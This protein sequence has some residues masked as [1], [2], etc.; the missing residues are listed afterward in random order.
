MTEKPGQDLVLDDQAQELYQQLGGID[1]R[2]RGRDTSGAGETFSDPLAEEQELMDLWRMALVD[3]IYALSQYLSK[4]KFHGAQSIKEG[5]IEPV[6]AALSSLHAMSK[7][8]ESV[9]IRYRGMRLPEEGTGFERIDYLATCGEFS[10]DLPIIKALAKRKGITMSHL[11]GKLK[12]AFERFPPLE[13]NSL[14]FIPGSWGPREMDLM[15]RSL[16]VAAHYFGAYKTQPNLGENKSAENIFPSVVYNNKG[17][18]D[19]NLTLLAGLNGLKSETIQSLLGQLRNLMKQPDSRAKLDQF[20]SDYDALFAFKKIREQL[21]RPPMEINNLSRLIV[22]SGKSAFT[23]EKCEL[24]RM[25]A[26]GFGQSHESLAQT[27]DSVYGNDFARVSPENLRLRLNRASDLLDSL[28]RRQ[29]NPAMEKEVLTNVETRLSQVRDDVYE[30]LWANERESI[31]RDDEPGS[32]RYRLSKKIED[33]FAFFKRRAHTKKKIKNIMRNAIDFDAHDYEMVARDFGIP[34]EEARVL[35]E[36]LKG[37][38]DD[39]GSFLRSSFE[40]SI[41]EMAKY[42]EKIFGFFWHYLKET[43]SRKDRVAFLNSLQSLIFH[44]NQSPV[45]LRF[46]LNDFCSVPDAVR[47]SDRNALIIANV[48]LRKYN[49]ELYNDI[50]I[51]PEEVLLVR[52]GLNHEAINAAGDVIDSQKD[53]FFEKIRSIHREM[54]NALQKGS[55]EKT[56]PLRFLLSLER[57]CFIFLALIGR[58]PGHTVLRSAVSTYGNPGSEIYR[59]ERKKGIEESCLKH[60]RVAVRGLSRYEDEID[61]R[62]L[63]QVKTMEPDFMSLRKDAHFM[64]SVQKTMQWVDS[65]IRIISGCATTG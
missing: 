63:T 40:K 62:L 20:I 29:P 5:E 21:Q 17:M 28:N 41:P 11:P 2:E 65:A 25:I 19:P 9:L 10:I 51:T 26:D 7:R 12:A 37:C 24:I 39:S 15:R 61:L 60:L 56:M 45:A 49:I 44:M 53:A 54:L 31:T 57:E 50:E 1:R 36:L 46:L 33:L 38:F 30:A 16:K 52:E 58:P 22:D 3:V 35:L 43:L 59:K 27:V 23:P 32:M 4:I 13:I 8:P 55:G 14:C 64:D 6:I 18:P 42:G 47:F 34:V 48:L